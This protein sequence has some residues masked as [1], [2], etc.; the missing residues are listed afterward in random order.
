M[1]FFSFSF[2]SL[3]CSTTK[4]SK[5][6]ETKRN[7]A[8]LSVPAFLI[9]TQNFLIKQFTQRI[10]G[11]FSSIKYLDYGKDTTIFETFSLLL[12]ITSE[13]GRFG[14]EK[15]TR[16]PSYKHTHA[17]EEFPFATSYMLAFVL[18]CVKQLVK[19]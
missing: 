5:F 13:N 8:H 17:Y 19:V 2:R 6:L 10:F 3:F 1:F 16:F 14:A 7:R 15:P 18:F 4:T 9:R 11:I 12:Q